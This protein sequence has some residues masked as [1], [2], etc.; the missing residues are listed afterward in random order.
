MKKYIILVLSIIVLLSL[1]LGT[2]RW[3]QQHLAP[4]YGIN[5]ITGC[6]RFEYV[7][8]HNVAFGIGSH[9]P[10]KIKQPIIIGVGILA[11]IFLASFLIQSK[12]STLLYISGV[13]IITGALGNLIDRLVNGYVVDFIHWF[14]N[15]FDWPVFNLADAY[16]TV[17][18]IL[19]II[20]FLFFSKPEK[21]T[22]PPAQIPAS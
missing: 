9:L 7:E 5:V 8:N 13:F 2:K 10:G 20:E 4:S 14:Y 12:K 22:E 3:A 18:M 21:P 17:G 6:W 1:D 16:V 11:L 19:L 15:G